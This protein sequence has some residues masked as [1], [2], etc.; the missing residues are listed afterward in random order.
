MEATF[1]CSICGDASHKICV[2]CTKDVCNNHL[3]HRCMRCSEC[4]HC[5]MPTTL[6]EE[7]VQT[8]KSEIDDV[9]ES[10]TAPLI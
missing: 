8:A 10:V 6:N 1:E 5:D 3:C 9:E 2:N 7:P 4:C